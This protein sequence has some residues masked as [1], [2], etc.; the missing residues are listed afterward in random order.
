MSED[1]E[2]LVNLVNEEPEIADDDDTSKPR[3]YVIHTYS[4]YENKVKANIEKIVNNRNMQDLIQELVI[5]V[6]ETVE[7]TKT[8]KEKKTVSKIYPTYVFVKMVM[9][10]DTWYVIRNTTGVTSF[11]G[12]GSK[13]VPLTLEE[14][15]SLGITKREI[16]CDFAVGDNVQV[17]SGTFEGEIGR[18]E[19]INIDKRMVT[20]WVDF[21]GRETQMELEFGQIKP[22]S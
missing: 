5:P 15:I 13:P 3:W 7:L 19:K 11:V 12:P 10:D 1:T 20:V 16:K 6:E 8:G 22:L 4:G 2:N 9:N 18:V 17:T 21:F 14:E